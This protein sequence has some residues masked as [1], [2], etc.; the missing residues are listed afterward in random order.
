MSIPHGAG[1]RAS[2]Q[3]VVDRCDYAR[4]H[5]LAKVDDALAEGMKAKAEEFR[6]GGGE[7]YREV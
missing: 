3:G 6:A 2:S 5:G 4:E 1:K 7:V